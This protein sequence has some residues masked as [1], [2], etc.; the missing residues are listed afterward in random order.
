MKTYE[1]LYFLIQSYFYFLKNVII[2]IC[3]GFLDRF[4]GSLLKTGFPLM[5]YVKVF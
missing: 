5:K 4:L 3:F 1:N 2:K